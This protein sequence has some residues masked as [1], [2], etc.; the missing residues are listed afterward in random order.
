MS[1]SV[2]YK[3]GRRVLGKDHKDVIENIS[4]SNTHSIVT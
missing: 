3:G 1:I 2:N 4:L